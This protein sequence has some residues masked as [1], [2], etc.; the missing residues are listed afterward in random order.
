MIYIDGKLIGQSIGRKSFIRYN[1]PAA[2][3][4]VLIT[5]INGEFIRSERLQVLP[6][7]KIIMEIE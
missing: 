1:L 4:R 5:G 6:F 3:Y 7:S 2:T